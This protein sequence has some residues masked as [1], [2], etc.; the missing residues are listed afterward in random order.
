MLGFSDTVGELSF[1]DFG[2]GSLLHEHMQTDPR[3]YLHIWNMADSSRQLGIYYL[4][5]SYPARWTVSS[6]F[7][8]FCL[9][10]WTKCSR[11]VV[12]F[13]LSTYFFF[14]Y[15]SL[16]SFLT[17]HSSR[18]SERYLLYCM[19]GSNIVLSMCS[20]KE[21]SLLYFKV[22]FTKAMSSK[23]CGSDKIELNMRLQ[24]SF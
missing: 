3:T 18:A 17:S 11:R 8:Q 9:S 23:A 1:P 14:Y 10:K 24:S 22:R 19:S 21:I 6:F 4:L 12:A 13:E 16:Y 7:S 15:L 20:Q 2:S 5:A